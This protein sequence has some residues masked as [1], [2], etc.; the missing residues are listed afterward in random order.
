M[1][2]KRNKQYRRRPVRCP[3]LVGAALVFGPI[4]AVLDQLENDGT[5]T[6]SSRGVPM[7]Q[8]GDGRWYETSA[9]LEGVIDHIDMWCARHGRTLPLDSLRELRRLIEYAM[10]IPASLMVRLR[11]DL[12]VL[13]AVMARG[14]SDDMVDLLTQVQI[15]TELEKL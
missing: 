1:S 14:N 13:Q 4:T 7:F 5:L 8:D 2:K 3:L 6:T 15:K 11:C 9:A 12:P 10:N